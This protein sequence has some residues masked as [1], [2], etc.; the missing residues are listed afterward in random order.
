M[1]AKHPTVAKKWAKE[2]K[3]AHKSIKKLPAR[4]GR[5]KK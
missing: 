4:K 2:M 5:K 1:F 3:A